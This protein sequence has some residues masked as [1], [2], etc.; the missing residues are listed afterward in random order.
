[1]AV[2][3]WFSSFVLIARRRTLAGLDKRLRPHVRADSG[4]ERNNINCNN[5]AQKSAT[6]LERFAFAR[7]IMNQVYKAVNRKVDWIIYVY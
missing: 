2:F 4:H 3:E 7:L 1:M 6:K 5:S